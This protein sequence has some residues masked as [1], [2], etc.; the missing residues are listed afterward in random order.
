MNQ[1]AVEALRHEQ[2]IPLLVAATQETVATVFIGR[3]DTSVIDSLTKNGINID[4][5]L[6]ENAD[7]ALAEARV[8][9]AQLPLFITSATDTTLAERFFKNPDVQGFFGEHWTQTQI[10]SHDNQVLHLSG[11]TQNGLRHLI[12]HTTNKT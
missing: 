7:E 3:D 5:V 8:S 6:C 2:Q 11:T 10:Q 12:Q 1:G 9:R 4:V